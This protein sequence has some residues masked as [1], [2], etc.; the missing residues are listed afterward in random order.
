MQPGTFWTVHLEIERPEI[1]KTCYHTHTQT[2]PPT[3]THCSILQ[4]GSLKFYTGQI[5]IEFIH[6][7]LHY[8]QHNHVIL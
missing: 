3:H 8:Y 5:C 1:T 4:C 6:L 2:H 7:K